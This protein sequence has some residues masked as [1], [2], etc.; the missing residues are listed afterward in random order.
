MA[1]QT[2]K[3]GSD[4]LAKFAK[5]PAANKIAIV[6]AIAAALGGVYYFLFYSDIAAERD[7]LAVARK[8]LADDEKKLQNRKKEYVELLQKKLDVEEELRRNAVRLPSSSELPAFFVHLQTQALAANVSLVKWKR[9][10]E[11]S[12]ESFV[13]VPVEMEVRG[14]F[15]QMT[16]YFKLLFDTPRIITIEDLKINAIERDDAGPTLTATFVAATFRQP[17]APARPATPVVVPAGK[18][19]TVVTPDGKAPATPPKA[20]GK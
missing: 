13:K 3:G 16:Q 12:V 8:R 4:P 19:G 11:V 10:N 17:D 5:Q 15:Y 6:L 14:D 9:D 20:G 18:P 7:S 1:K 2:S